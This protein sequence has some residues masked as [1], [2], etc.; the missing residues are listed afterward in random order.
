MLFCKTLVLCRQPSKLAARHVAAQWTRFDG[1]ALMHS[2]TFNDGKMSGSV[3]LFCDIETQTRSP[4]GK[5]ITFLNHM[6]PDFT[7]NCGNNFIRCGKDCYATSE[8]NYIQSRSCDSEDSGQGNLKLSLVDYLKYLAVN[9]VTSHP[10]YDK[11][12]TAYNMGTSIAEKGKTKYTLFK[13]PDTTAGD[14]AKASPALKNLEVICTVP[15]RSLLSPSYY[16]SLSMTGNHFIFIEQPFKLDI[17]K[18]ATAYMRGVNWASCLKFF[19]EENVRSLIDRKT[20][21]EVGI[22]YYTEAMIV[23]HHVNAFEEDGHVIFDV[24]A[25]EDPNL[26]N[27]FYIDVLKEQSKTSAMSVQKICPSCTDWQDDMVKLKYTTASAVKEKEDKL[28]CQPEVLCDGK[29]KTCIAQCSVKFLC[30][31]DTQNT[32]QPNIFFHNILER[33]EWR[34][35]N[36]WPSEP[37]FIPRPDGEGEDGVVLTTVINSNPGESG[38]ILVLDAK[39]FKEVARAYV[40]AELHMDMHGYVIPKEN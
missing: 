2:F 21:K 40:N 13:V 9:L 1:M 20:G 3:S 10:H 35:E 8:T 19:P 29:T 18:M 24:I 37:V 25:Y 28:L 38:F 36:C 39:S 34:E 6:V 30:H 16:H 33:T 5:V 27:M 4:I 23:Y 14:K 7:D 32:Y 31:I 17:L 15:C 22:K 12:G 11:D 26:Y